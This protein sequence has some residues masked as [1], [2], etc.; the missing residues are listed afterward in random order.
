MRGH[1]VNGPMSVSN[2]TAIYIKAANKDQSISNMSYHA[3]QRGA[4]GWLYHVL[5]DYTNEKFDSLEEETNRILELQNRYTPENME[6]LSEFVIN[7][8]EERVRVLNQL[9]QFDRNRIKEFLSIIGLP[10][11]FKTM[12]ALPC[13]MGKH[14]NKTGNACLYCEFSIKTINAIR[15]YK[16]ELYT[17]I[18]RLS[19]EIDDNC[20]KKYMYLAY[21]ILLVIKDIRMEFG[22]EYLASYIDM[23]DIKAKMDSLPK[24]STALLQEVL[25]GNSEHKTKRADK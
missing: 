2:T 9:K 14:C 24:K 20:I 17:I 25:D 12:Q 1:K 15:I 21:K 22:T 5:L 18:E 4:F 10:G 16:N 19:D 8:T 13:I 6:D 11:T 3:T 7:D 23:V